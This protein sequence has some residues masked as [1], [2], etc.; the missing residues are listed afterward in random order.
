MTIG[1]GVRWR[2]VGAMLL[3]AEKSSRLRD[4]VRL[5]V[6][7]ARRTAR[8]AARRTAHRPHQPVVTTPEPD[9]LLDVPQLSIDRIELELDSL[10][11]R[12]ALQARV[13]DMVTLDVGA[14]A[15]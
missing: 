6:R 11:A 9:V 12:V 2:S 7:G 8:R 1:A 14:D 13:L 10:T 15:S 5:A 4:G 3:P